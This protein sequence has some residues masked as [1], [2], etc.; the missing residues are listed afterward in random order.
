MTLGKNI[1]IATDFSEL[2]QRAVKIGFELA[3]RLDGKVHLVHVFT[4]QGAPESG[5]LTSEALRDAELLAAGKLRVVADAYRDS[6]RLG[7]VKTRHGDPAPMILLT[8][9]ELSADIIVLGT[10]G[11]RGLPRLLLGSTAESVLRLATCTVVII[12]QPE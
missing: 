4:L 9:E 6:G 3:A 7:E 8:A 2:G 11:R 1:V 12:K 5:A 10:H